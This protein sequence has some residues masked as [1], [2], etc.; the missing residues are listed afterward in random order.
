LREENVLGAKEPEPKQDNQ[1]LL[2]SPMIEG[3]ERF[4]S[5]GTK[6]PKQDS[7]NLLRSPMIEGGERFRSKRTKSP[8][9]D[10]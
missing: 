4:R 7:Q 2:R 3:G 9:Q 10:N 6:S 8:K 1:S 5:K